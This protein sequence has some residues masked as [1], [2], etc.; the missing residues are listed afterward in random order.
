MVYVFRNNTIERFLQG[1]Y[2]FSGYD[3][4][5]EVPSADAYLWWYQIPYKFDVDKLVSEVES[6]AE[7]LRYVSNQIGCKQLVVLTLEKL[8]NVSSNQS[9]WR[10]D[11][12]VGHFNQTARDIA[13]EKQSVKIIDFGDFVREFKKSELIDWKFYFMSQ[14]PINP[15][16]SKDFQKWMDKQMSNVALKR[17]KCLVLDLDNTLW[18]GVLG[19]DGLEGVQLDGDYPGK[20]YHLWQEGLKELAENGVILTICSKN[21]EKDV[22]ELWNKRPSMV[23]KDTDFACKKINWN[24]KASNIRAI[25]EELNIGLDS[26]VFVDDNPSERELIKQELPMVAVPEWPAQPYDLPA[27]YGNL[28][29]TY[30]KVYNVT[31]E[32]KKKTE[33]YRQNALR[34]QSQSHFTNMEDFIRSLEIRM[35][36]SKVTAVTIARVSQMTQKTNQ[37]NLTTHRYTENDIQNLIDK[38]A[39]IYTLSVSDRFG[40]NGVTGCIILCPNDCGWSVDTFLLSCRILGKGIETAFV[41]SVLSDLDKSK[42]IESSYFA[43]AKNGQVRDF[44]DKIG[45]RLI[46]ETEKEKNYL[47]SLD[48]LDLT[49]KDYY[50][51]EKND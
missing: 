11:E 36:I 19:E 1:D 40:D 27:F 12:A 46:S 47:S 26:F 50:K 33:Q 4:F 49:I 18:G 48:S 6:Y 28:V 37:F 25:A 42:S 9:D 29:E 14:M 2:S 41:K 20:A 21:N 16:L 34:A 38:G 3:D 8:F 24:D 22:D 51:I 10:L 45:F 7:K 17:K 15:R 30:F 43:T 32:D 39:L 44:Y 31:D 35:R 5:S 23:L 13:R